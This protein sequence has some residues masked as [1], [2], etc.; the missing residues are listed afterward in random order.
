MGT[1]S[2][3]ALVEPAI[4]IWARQSAGLS[5][6][7]AA[8]SLQAKPEN[9][10]AWEDGAKAPS[11]AQLRKM[12]TVYKRLLSDF[13][14]ASPPA[15]APLPHD[16]RRTP[17]DGHFHYSRA[18][19]YR[20]R[21]AQQR[22]T[23]ALDLAAELEGEIPKLPLR[24]D[25]ETD[26]EA[27][28]AKV[29]NMLGIS[30]AEQRGWRDARRS[31]NAWRER[32]EAAGVLVFQVTDVDTN[33]VLG[34]SLPT[35]PMPVLA[36]NR[37]LLP[38]GRTF[39]LLHEL[40]HILI[41]KSSL[42]D[43]VDDGFRSSEEQDVEVFCNAVAGAALVPLDLLVSDEIVRQYP[44]RA[45]DW[46][47]DELSTIARNFSVSKYV[48]LRRL[49]TAGRTTRTFYAARAA[50]Y[51]FVE[52]RPPV[53]PEAEIKRNMPQEVLSNLGRPFTRLILESYL[54]ASLSLS[55]ASRYLGLRAGQVE[56]V[57]ELMLGG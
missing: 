16:F 49:L 19:R 37:K 57:R 47:D 46:G 51:R 12:A 9:L 40:A 8:R 26:P 34:F 27:A 18:L 2:T 38:N 17:G 5:V 11:M 22:R 32:I 1:R 53:D 6:E 30:A 7:G 23:L 14:Y 31:Y 52:P 44:A 36:V 20:L 35:E 48:I 28:G 41:G 25:E 45:R 55:D 13:Y 15:E 10:Q 42:C 39:T 56:R 50:M 3:E 24:L 33:E 29:R 4:L 21:E 54:N 43:I